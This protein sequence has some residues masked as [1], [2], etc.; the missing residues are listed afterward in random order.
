M[1]LRIP[2][3]AET[4]V[5][6]YAHQSVLIEDNPLSLGDTMIIFDELN[7]DLFKNIDIGS[8][9]A[10]E[11]TMLPRSETQARRDSSPVIELKNHIIA[12]QW[13]AE[14]AATQLGTAGLTEDETRDLAAMAIKGTESEAVYTMGWGGRVPLGGYRRSPISVRSNPLRVFPYP[15]EVPACI[16]RFFEWR[17]LQHREKELHPLIL[18]CQ[19]T[20]YYVH[21]HP[22]PDGN[23]RVSRMIMHDYLVRQ[24]Y[25]PVVM[26]NLERK[27]YLRMISNACD[28][29]PREFVDS[30]LTTQLDELITF[31]GHV[32]RW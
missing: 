32:M 26:Q 30:V 14:N 18:A 9:P 31:Y 3:L 8:M 25:L 28:G 7:N 21:I 12:S 11:L 22:F 4:L 6:E 20:A 10:K 13:I 1:E 27:D 2:K 24:G 29:E 23:G 15:P 16:Q 17:D 19:M 5:A